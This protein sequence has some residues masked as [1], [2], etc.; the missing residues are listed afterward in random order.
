M[1]K[2]KL[3]KFIKKNMI[4]EKLQTIKIIYIHTQNVSF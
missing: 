4:K 3:Y 1:I 2:E